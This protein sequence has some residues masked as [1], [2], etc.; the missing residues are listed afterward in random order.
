MVCKDKDF[1]NVEIVLVE[2]RFTLSLWQVRPY[3]KLKGVQNEPND[4]FVF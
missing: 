2:K 1:V 3:I 4:C